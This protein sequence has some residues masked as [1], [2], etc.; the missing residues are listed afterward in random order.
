MLI[1]EENKEFME[2]DSAV[3]SYH[4]CVYT[5]K[6]NF[7]FFECFSGFIATEVCS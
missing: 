2:F 3:S 4:E 7:W 1:I 6:P 5:T